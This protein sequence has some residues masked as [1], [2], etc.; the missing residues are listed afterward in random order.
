MVVS[1]VERLDFDV[2]HK[3]HQSTMLRLL[4]SGVKKHMCAAYSVHFEDSIIII[5]SLLVSHGSSQTPL[6]E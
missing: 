6:S 2:R 3:G 1:P 5:D 4:G